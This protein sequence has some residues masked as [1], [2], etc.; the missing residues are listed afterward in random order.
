MRPYVMRKAGKLLHLTFT[1]KLSTR[2]INGITFY[3][4]TYDSRV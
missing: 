1:G 4:L 2:E 3:I